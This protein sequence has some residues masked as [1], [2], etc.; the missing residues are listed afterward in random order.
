M[1]LFTD[2][3]IKNLKAKD[4]IYD[5]REN[6]GF[7]IRIFPSG[8]KSWVF[9]YTHNGRKR[10]MTLGSYKTMSLAQ[11]RIKYNEAYKMLK[12]ESKDPALAQKQEKTHNRDSSSIDQLIDEYIEKW[13]KKRKRSWKED[14]RLLNKEVK[15]KWGKCKAKDIT[16]RDVVLLLED[17]VERGTPIAANRAFACI[18]RMFNFA[19]ERD[20]VTSTPCTAI[21]A[22]AKENQRDRCLSQT[23]IKSF[24]VNL[25]KAYMSE[26]TRLALKLQLVTAQRKGEILAAEWNE[27]NLDTKLWIIPD[28]KAKNGIEHRVPLSTLA[29]ELIIKLK[30]ITGKSRWLFPS[31][32]SKLHMRGE[33]VDRAVRRSSEKIFQQ[34]NIKH[35]TP[36]DL[37]RTAATHMTSIGIP[38]LVVSKILN[39][40]DSSITAIYD[41]HSY[42]AEK[43]NALETWGNKV[44]QFIGTTENLTNI[45][46]PNPL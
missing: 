35:F 17:I 18:R 6:N 30:K 37:R 33:S 28:T 41:R 32:T 40:A 4:H 11:A 8:E 9:I 42:D 2:K 43:L 22:P 13:A 36:H 19:V 44:K 34:A 10:R 25:D 15:P 27:I 16:K 26:A 24:W 20:L 3:K 46:E 1:K 14:Q 45:V 29:I 12:V 21:K 23:E 38:R 31:A 5:I 39:H 7:A